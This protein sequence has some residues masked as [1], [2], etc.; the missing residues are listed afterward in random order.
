Y[1]RRQMVVPASVDLNATV[2][3]LAPMGRRLGGEDIEGG[4]EPPQTDGSVR[5]DPGQL[6]QVLLNLVANARDAMPSGGALRLRTRRV[7]L[8][9]AAARGGPDGAPG[10]APPPRAGAPAGG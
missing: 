3:G 4:T 6:E 9:S 5:V 8:T 1:A 10:P 2:S 7:A